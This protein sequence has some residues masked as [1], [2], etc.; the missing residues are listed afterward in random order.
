MAGSHVCVKNPTSTSGY[1]YVRAI[2]MIGNGYT[3]VLSERI[4]FAKQYLH[5]RGI[6]RF[7]THVRD[8]VVTAGESRNSRAGGKRRGMQEGHVRGL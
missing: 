3:A 5:V 2:C 7:G 1:I 8:E 4:D 6:G